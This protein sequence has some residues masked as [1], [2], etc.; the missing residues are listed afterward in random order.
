[1]LYD[2]KDETDFICNYYE[3]AR[4]NPCR[5]NFSRAS[6]PYTPP[7]QTRDSKVCVCHDIP[8]GIPEEKYTQGHY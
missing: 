4:W 3:L 8:C 7:T 2:Y 6:V 1:M 5:H